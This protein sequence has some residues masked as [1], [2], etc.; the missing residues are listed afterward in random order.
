MAAAYRA[1]GF[2]RAVPGQAHPLARFYAKTAVVMQPYAR[3]IDA[4]RGPGNK[5]PRIH[6]IM[7][8]QER[9]YSLWRTF[10][11][12]EARAEATTRARLRIFRRFDTVRLAQLERLPLGDVDYRPLQ[13]LAHY[14]RAH[15]LAT[16]GEVPQRKRRR[17]TARA[18]F[19]LARGSTSPI[20][21]LGP[22]EIRT[23]VLL[24]RIKALGRHSGVGACL[25]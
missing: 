23:T 13:Q 8:L 7:L 15:Q 10:P 1:A 16:V 2:D 25:P 21:A 22:A 14:M 18:H 24:A 3:R 9:M 6:R 17:L 20:H 19:Y 5:Q 12:I 11:A 4:M